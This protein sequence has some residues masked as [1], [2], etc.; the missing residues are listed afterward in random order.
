MI[1]LAA[2]SPADLLYIITAIAT[3]AAVFTSFIGAIS[4]RIWT[5]KQARKVVPYNERMKQLTKSLNDASTSVDNVL[6]E[7]AQIIQERE[8]AVT[9]LEQK[10][11]LIQRYIESLEKGPAEPLKIFHEILAEQAKQQDKESRKLA[12]RYFIYGSLV[13]FLG[14]G[15]GVY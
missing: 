13:T 4:F 6:Q 12:R 15:I 5:R 8:K 11:M 3:I 7:M 2:M 14:T 9:T 1:V 10:Q